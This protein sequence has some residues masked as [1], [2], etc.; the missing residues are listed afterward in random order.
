MP[1]FAAALAE[2]DSELAGAAT[3]NGGMDGQAGSGEMIQKK[4][5]NITRSGEP[6]VSGPAGTKSEQSI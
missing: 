1:N 6:E 5:T 4:W 2:Q 3:E